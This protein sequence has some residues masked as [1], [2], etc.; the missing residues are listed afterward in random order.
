MLLDAPLREL[1]GVLPDT[2]RP[3]NLLSLIRQNDADVRSEAVRIDHALTPSTLDLRSYCST[4]NMAYQTG[5]VPC[6]C[7]VTLEGEL[8]PPS[9]V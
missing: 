2:T 4:D 5:A 9:K 8:R 6:I 7:R 3:Q 1:P